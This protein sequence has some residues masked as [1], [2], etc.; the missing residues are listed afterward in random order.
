[1]PVINLKR[2]I[3]LISRAYSNIK[4]HSKK[5]PFFY[6]V[7]SGISSNSIPLAGEMIKEFEDKL[8]KEIS[9]QKTPQNKYSEYF[10]EV[11]NEPAERRDYLYNLM[12]DA[13]ITEANLLLAHLLIKKIDFSSLVITT[14][15]DNLLSRA[16]N[17]FGN[18]PLVF[19]HPNSLERINSS[20][21]DKIQIV[22]VHG[23]YRFYDCCNLGFEIEDRANSNTTYYSSVF[24]Y[25][26]NV[27]SENSPLI[28]GY[29]GWNDV[30]LRALKQRLKSGVGYHY[31][32]FCYDKVSFLNIDTELKKNPYL[33]L[34]VNDHSIEKQEDSILY[35]EKLKSSDI[36]KAP[37]KNSVSN[38][39][40]NSREINFTNENENE[41]IK[42][43][44]ATKV[45]DELKKALKTNDLELFDKPIEF[46]KHQ[47]D[48]LFPQKNVSNS[49]YS[50]DRV[51]QILDRAVLDY[52]TISAST[53]IEDSQKE[54]TKFN[55]ELHTLGR[56]SNYKEI[57]NK[58]QNEYFTHNQIN[59]FPVKHKLKVLEMLYAT[60]RTLINY[61]Q[62]NF[63]YEIFQKLTFIENKEI[64]KKIDEI[65]MK[66]WFEHA[67]LTYELHGAEKSFAEF[68]Q[69]DK[70][71]GLSA[72]NYLDSLLK[73]E[74][75]EILYRIARYFITKIRNGNYNEIH[76]KKIAFSLF[77]KITQLSDDKE[78]TKIREIKANAWYEKAKLT[79][80]INGWEQAITEHN[81]LI[82]EFKNDK[83]LICKESVARALYAL[84]YIYDYRKD[85]ESAL[86]PY[87]RIITLFENYPEGS[88][89]INVAN[90]ILCLGRNYLRIGIKKENTSEK[91]G[92]FDLAEITLRK[93]IKEYSKETK[94]EFKRVIQDSNKNL[95]ILT[96]VKDKIQKKKK[97]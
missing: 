35:E 61:S 75:A 3:E 36:I 93:V 5:S 89:K 45:F 30:V 13:P 83:E 69:I 70:I 63:A 59:S 26:M 20:V 80:E 18:E 73:A 55:E 62:L 64:E 76:N 19:D 10:E 14:N 44:P 48:K 15:F 86:E 6:I 12:K 96:E 23:S 54:I 68:N 43:L 22:H 97:T 60:G 57:I 11:Y 39:R 51:R 91:N 31:F 92:F 88:L 42:P 2:A 32:W 38:S 37:I 25:L 78:D 27:L 66:A 46:F 4:P 16:L 95:D 29:S 41:K 65:K 17:L 82:N 52:T 34:V 8:G 9:I 28:I 40:N 47:L 81:N 87:Q 77:K 24:N 94:S 1:M 71:Y 58:I 90:A 53:D 33:Y 50:F 56:N 85:Y 79:Y 7:G 49:F 72:I 21:K 74:V 67:N 84:G